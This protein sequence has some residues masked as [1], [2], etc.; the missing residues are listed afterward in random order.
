MANPPLPEALNCCCGFHNSN[1]FDGGKLRESPRVVVRASVSLCSQ[2]TDRYSVLMHAVQIAKIQPW[3][4]RHRSC[5]S[6]SLI[7]S[8][9]DVKL[10][11]TTEELA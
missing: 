10:S 4:A 3:L 7:C 1:D 8:F 11:M 9:A 2:S 6:L 5:S